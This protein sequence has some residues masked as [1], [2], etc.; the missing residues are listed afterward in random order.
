MGW[1]I[2]LVAIAAWGVSCVT[3]RRIGPERQELSALLE[4]TPELA[5]RLEHASVFAR[6]PNGDAWAGAGLSTRVGPR[7]GAPWT[8]ALDGRDLLTLTAEGTP[9]P[10]A[11]E[12]RLAVYRGAHDALDT[13]VVGGAD[14]MEWFYVAR[15]PERVELSVRVDDLAGLGAPR[16]FGGGLEWRDA[17]G[18]VLR[19]PAPWAVD[20]NGTRHT[21][22]LRFADGRIHLSL[23]A[24]GLPA[25]IVI[26]P[27]L[28]AVRWTV[29]VPT[30]GQ[31]RG[32]TSWNGRL[33]IKPFF[34]EVLWEL[35][36]TSWIA[37]KPKV[38][39]FKGTWELAAAGDRMVA[40]QGGDEVWEF[41][42]A[43]WGRFLPAVRPPTRYSPAFGSHAGKALAF[44]GYAIVGGAPTEMTDTWTWSSGAWTQIS[45]T[46]APA[47]AGL[48]HQTVEIAGKT[49]LHAVSDLWAFAGGT[50]TKATSGGPPIFEDGTLLDLG[51]KPCLLGGGSTDAYVLEGTGWTKIAAITT[52]TT[53]KKARAGSVAGKTFVVSKDRTYTFDG[54]KLTPAFEH[55]TPT[56]VVAMTA[57]G[58]R[59]VAVAGPSGDETWEYD[60]AAWTKKSPVTSLPGR[61]N[62]AIATLGGKAVVFGGFDSSTYEQLAD[63]WEW[64]GS[65]WTLRTPTTKPAARA[66]HSM[67]G[68]GSKVVLYGGGGFVGGEQWE[69][70]GSNWQQKV[71]TPNPGS[72][73]LPGLAVV[74]GKL[75]L[76][77]GL[78]GG[79]GGGPGPF[80]LWEYDGTTWTPRTPAHVPSSATGALFASLGTR[81]VLHGGSGLIDETWLWDG[82]D[83]SRLPSVGTPD[84]RVEAASAVMGGDVYLVGG[85]A[86]GGYDVGPELWRMR[87]G[88]AQGVA[89]S[90]ASE[91]ATGACVDGVC[92]STDC[93]GSCEACNEPGFVGQCIPIS[94]APRTGHAACASTGA[95][96]PCAARCDG[97]SR[98]SCVFAKSGTVCGKNGCAKGVSTK[99]GTCD[100]A[101]ACSDSP[102][103][104]APYGCKDETSCATSCASDADCAPSSH[105]AASACVPKLAD[106]T[107]AT[108]PSACTSGFVADGVCCNKPCAGVCEA[109]D[110]SATIGTCTPVLGKARHGTCP[111]PAGGSAC[112]A[113]VC[114]G[115]AGA[116]CAAFVSAEVS[117]RPR[118]CV[119]GVE[120]LPAS[121]NGSGSCPSI[122]TKKCAPLRC[123]ESACK[124]SC[125]ADADCVEGLECDVP[126]GKCLDGATCDG[127]HTVRGAKGGDIDCTPYRC[128]GAS[129]RT[130]CSVSTDCVSGHACDPGTGACVPLATAPPEEEGGCAVGARGRAKTGFGSLLLLGGT[131]MLLR[132]RRAGAIAAASL[133]L[134]ACSTAPSEPPTL[135]IEGD[136]V[137]ALRADPEIAARLADAVK[138]DGL[139]A[140]TPHGRVEAPR[141]VPG[142]LTLAGGRSV[143][144]S[145]AGTR[146]TAPIEAAPGTLVYRDALPST[147]LVLIA[148]TDGA[149]EIA[150]VARD[151]GAPSRVSLELPAS[152]TPR[153][154][155]QGVLLADATGATVAAL[156][157]AHA[158]DARGRRFDLRP[159]ISGTT[160]SLAV[161]ADAAFPVVIDPVLET[162]RWTRLSGF[163]PLRTKVSAAELGGKLY[164]VGSAGDTWAYDSSTGWSDTGAVSVLV[165]TGCNDMAVAGSRLVR[166]GADDATW[167]FD[168]ASWRASAMSPQP[169]PRICAAMVSMGSKV[170][171]HGGQRATDKVPLDDTWEFDGTRWT[172]LAPATSPP[173]GDTPLLFATSGGPVLFVNGYNETWRWS[174]TDW[175]K[176]AG[177]QTINGSRG[178][179]RGGTPTI[180]DNAGAGLWEFGGSAWSLR[181]LSGGPATVRGLGAFGARLLA[182]GDG[183]PISG[184][185]DTWTFDGT[186]WSRSSE[187]ALPPSSSVAA[188]GGTHVVAEG[189]LGTWEWSGTSWSRKSSAVP[190]KPGYQGAL[191]GLSDRAAHIDFSKRTWQEW[192]GSTWSS[193]TPSSWPKATE[194]VSATSLGDRVLLWGGGSF[195]GSA[196]YVSSAETWECSPGTTPSCTSK[197][198][199]VIPSAFRGVMAR[200]G[201][202]ATLARAGRYYYGSP[203]TMW[204]WTGADW[205]A[206]S[207]VFQPTGMYNGRFVTIGSRALLY[208]GST[209]DPLSDVAWIWDGA[210]WS[211]LVPGS[212]VPNG[213]F[214]VASGQPLVVDQGA[215]WKGEILGAKGGDCASA[216]D[217]LSGFCVDGKCCDGAC[218]GRCEA[219]NVPGKEGACSAVV[220]APVGS[221]PACATTPTEC[222]S[223]CDGVDRT[224]CTL[225]K[226]GLACGAAKC[227]DGIAAVPGTCDGAGNCATTT[228]TCAPY[229]CA[230]DGCGTTCASDYECDPAAWC[231][232]GACVPKKKPGDAATEGRA[233]T[234][235]L[236][237]DGVC[238]N[239]PCTGV[240]EACDLEATKGTCT[241]RA[242]A[243]KHGSCP[244]PAS[245]DP[246]V[247]TS[248]DGKTGNACAAYPG[249]DV[250]CGAAA[251]TDGVERRA[252]SCNG[253]GACPAAETR[254]CAPYACG[255]ITCLEAC[256]EDDECAPGNRC[257][258][259]KCVS[260]STCEDDRFVVSP[261]GSKTNCAPFRCA[262]GACIE[263]CTDS[264]ACIV[265]YA[266]DTSSGKCAPATGAPDGD[267]GGCTMNAR[268]HGRSGWLVVVSAIVVA[269]RRRR[270]RCGAVSAPSTPR[271]RAPLRAPGA[272]A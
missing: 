151:A 143:T 106:G 95:G 233:C 214:V 63:T 246:C 119:D 130:T 206:Q 245:T 127:E 222:G 132:R 138:F 178:V 55:R 50:W 160:Y 155:G 244:K 252:V 184:T 30:P 115:V 20:A 213:T 228:K 60:G 176:L 91:C 170:L 146:E 23:D 237:A 108:D 10:L 125:A 261:A 33:W 78:F 100:G 158:R 123:G 221:R 82:T 259:G 98:T 74:N 199:T 238:C 27:A 53:L 267:E 97:T 5:Q 195:E 8:L 62:T 258:E 102:I 183:D 142:P 114:D 21:V 56:N 139:V 104:C 251:C 41:D 243:A 31:E 177:A 17:D 75:L 35:D 99:A 148:G 29:V 116:S 263:K 200:H 216:S 111:A 124:E 69:W 80:D 89:C 193:R 18:P 34:D 154:E 218:S 209:P 28:E 260:S 225:P 48:G 150:W 1:R 156:R 234:T 112:A 40:W 14:A 247:A 240:C 135:A 215:M 226:A 131:M 84:P 107:A 92:C 117:C 264:N 173:V 85:S 15:R 37:H 266:C 42:G 204:T 256:A 71:L 140:R 19:M 241:P 79:S 22:A 70:D 133:A 90:A 13:I 47:K 58:A 197:P 219:C 137:A 118:S 271:R 198:T 68:F 59:L 189:P 242:G 136:R 196:G 162:F 175:V 73:Y 190:E 192:D 149:V 227:K 224:A 66:F 265:G 11:L 185:H 254:R 12:G 105:C 4:R 101:G 122:E 250:S 270:S 182:F 88:K 110:L 181:S 174:G 26:D 121:C 249:P 87:L 96:T 9:V 172:K 144:V 54:A 269:V 65:T 164:A 220:G 141:T 157:S 61:R 262:D 231:D 188:W 39:P 186:S 161:P 255:S 86:L 24:R 77:G 57:L 211:K 217:C 232:A 32:M 52:D 103:A 147:D 180:V 239:T 201:S 207:P 94:G 145:L 223:S 64:D 257:R 2:V 76:T 44:G 109:C 169:S 248:C 134:G 168:G 167:L 179:S 43:S 187:R 49:Y 51:G 67:V 72:R 45:T 128:A 16:A 229:R 159:E 171:L 126:S 3:D 129:C 46:T 81:A 120:T 166:I 191:Y 272:H 268:S 236:V 165:G 36:G 230:G 152:L 113:T 202:S 205:K 6:A 25:P 235:G 38:R 83:W 208:G 253:S 194:D 210:A 212:V 93:A 153:L 163:V 7:Y 203:G